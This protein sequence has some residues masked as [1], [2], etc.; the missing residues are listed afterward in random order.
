MFPQV[1]RPE[2]SMVTPD[3]LSGYNKNTP[4]GDV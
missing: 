3:A 1:G 4:P 2:L